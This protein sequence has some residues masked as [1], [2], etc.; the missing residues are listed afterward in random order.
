M[1]GIA[2]PKKSNRIDNVYPSIS[3]KKINNPSLFYAFPLFGL[4]IKVIM[5]IPVAI[6]LVFLGL[7]SFILT[8]INSFVVLF[9]GKYLRHSYEINLGLTRLSAK[10]TFFILGLTDKYPGFGLGIKD[11]FKVDVKYPNNPN[12]LFAI[13]IVGGLARLVLL[14]PF[15][16][17]EMVIRYAAAIGVV[18]SAFPVL[19]NKKYPDSTF[20]LARDSTRLNLA[21]SLY[22]FGMSDK[23]PSF[24][25]SMNHKTVKIILIILGAIG[26]IFYL[27][28]P[29]IIPFLRLA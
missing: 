17:Y 25:I 21:V 14:I 22:I 29:L 3:I 2:I 8:F 7:Y 4:L 23:Y 15:S 5:T 20:E 10:V 18:F 26:A 9:T 19:I 11:K 1:R 13:P 6:E 24:S 27:F 12:R 16:I 28:Y